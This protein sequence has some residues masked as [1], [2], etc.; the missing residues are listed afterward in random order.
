MKELKCKACN[1]YL[2]VIRDGN[3]AKGIVFICKRCDE[4]R[5]K[6]SIIVCEMYKVIG[7]SPFDEIRIKAVG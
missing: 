3:L 4:Q 1:T 2:G 6:D 5:M 7:S